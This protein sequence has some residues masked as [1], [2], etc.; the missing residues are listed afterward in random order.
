LPLRPDQASMGP[1]KR[2]PG[3]AV[4]PCS[5]LFMITLER[6]RVDVP[7]KVGR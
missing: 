5:G 4:E 1:G 6:L 7:S 2:S 3:Q